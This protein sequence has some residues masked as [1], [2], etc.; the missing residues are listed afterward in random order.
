MSGMTK[1][2]KGILELF[3]QSCSVSFNQFDTPFHYEYLISPQIVMRSNASCIFNAF[4]KGCAPFDLQRIIEI[5]RKIKLLI[6]HEIPDSAGANAKKKKFYSKQLPGNCL[7]DGYR[8]CAAHKVHNIAKNATNEEQLI[9]DVHAISVIEGKPGH[10]SALHR[11]L[12]DM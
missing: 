12:R 5:G 11:K 10:R 1:P 6:V 3:A 4:E 9:G 8:G 2:S 7:Y